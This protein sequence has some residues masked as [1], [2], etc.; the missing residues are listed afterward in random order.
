MPNIYCY[1]LPSSAVYIIV[2]ATIIELDNGPFH[3]FRWESRWA[4]LILNL[5]NVM[6]KPFLL[7][8]WPISYVT[9]AH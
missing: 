6:M 9:L 3:T 5:V 1:F 7:S 4:T 8:I 2:S